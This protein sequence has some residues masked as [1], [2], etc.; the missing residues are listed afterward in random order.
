[1]KVVVSELPDTLKKKLPISLQL[2]NEFD[3]S[4]ILDPKL[5]LSIESYI[6]SQNNLSLFSSRSSQN[7]PIESSLYKAVGK[8]IDEQ[9]GVDKDKVLDINFELTEYGLLYIT[10]LVEF[11]VFNLRNFIRTRKGVLLFDPGYGSSIFDILKYLD[12][13]TAATQIK[14]EIEK[15]LSH[16]VQILNTKFK[17]NRLQLKTVSISETSTSNNSFAGVSYNIFISLIINDEQLDITDELKL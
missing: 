8:Y 5:R 4:L 6:N 9:D 7:T 2:T 15:F 11:V 13:N 1:M 14:R 17:I 16:L 10:D 3:S 12:T